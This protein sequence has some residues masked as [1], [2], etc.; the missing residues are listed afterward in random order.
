MVPVC[1]CF[2]ALNFHLCA[3]MRDAVHSLFIVIF[4]LVQLD[5]MEHLGEV[6]AER[7]GERFR[8]QNTAHGQ[9]KST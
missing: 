1:H 2:D 9:T 7:E 5:T 8:M 6:D 3:H 4:I